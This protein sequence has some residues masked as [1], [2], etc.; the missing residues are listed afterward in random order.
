VSSIEQVTRV[1][2]STSMYLIS[3]V[4]PLPLNMLLL[5]SIS[6]LTGDWLRI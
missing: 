4:C 1:S 2:P 3:L 6:Q 5:P